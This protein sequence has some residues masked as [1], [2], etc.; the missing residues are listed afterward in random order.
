MKL[1]WCPDLASKAYIDGVRVIADQQDDLGGPS[2]VAELVSAMAG[3]WNAQLIVEA[4]DVSEASSSSSSSTSSSPS[5]RRSGPAATS[6]ALAAAARRTGGRY[7][8]VL[9]DAVS[10]VAYAGS[11]GAPLFQPVVGDADEA[12]ARLEGVDLLVVDARRRDAAA[13][14]RAARPGPRGMVVVRHGDGRR[15]G[16]AAAVMAAGTRVVRSVYLPIGKGGVE[17]LHV[18]VGKGPSL[19]TRA[20]AGR[21]IRH[22]NHDTGEEHV[23]RRQ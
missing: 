4:P 5:T 8:C 1:V 14:L 7:A 23:F 2:E 9:P 16:A 15:R 20:V 22:V 19:Q 21:W 18:G 10:A 11:G 13:V 6:L 17:V 12:M 3:G